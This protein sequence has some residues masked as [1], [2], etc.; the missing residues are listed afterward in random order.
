MSGSRSSSFSLSWSGIFGQGIL[1]KRIKSKKVLFLLR[2]VWFF[3]FFYALWYFLSPLYNHVLAPPSEL[4]LKLS[5]IRGEHITKAIQAK[6]QYIFV[7]YVVPEKDQDLAVQ[8]KRRVLQFGS[9]ELHFWMVFLFALIWAVPGI[10]WRK[11]LKIF[12]FGFV[13]IFGLHVFEIFVLVKREYSLHITVDG[14]SYWSPAQ[15]K[16]YYYLGDFI[17]LVLNQV[18]PVVIWSLLYWKYWWT[19]PA[20][21]QV[22]RRSANRMNSS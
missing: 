10:S 2:L 8:P 20:R 18:S 14:V 11:R 15:Q 12:L 21:P 22:G 19:R 16:I 4:L 17:V 1:S 5:E 3:L 7:H 9:R 13:I 6:G